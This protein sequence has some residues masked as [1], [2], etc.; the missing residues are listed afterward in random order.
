V[1]L[2]YTEPFT[3]VILK[4]YLGSLTPTTSIKQLHILVRSEP[5]V[6][7]LLNETPKASICFLKPKILPKHLKVP[8]I[9]RSSS[10][11]LALDPMARR[12]KIAKLVRSILL[13]YEM[14]KILSSYVQLRPHVSFLSHLFFDCRRNSGQGLILSTSIYEMIRLHFARISVVEQICPCRAATG[15]MT[16]IVTLLRIGLSKKNMRLVIGPSAFFFPFL[17]Y[18]SL[19]LLPLCACMCVCIYSYW[20]T[21]MT[22]QI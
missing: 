15:N 2:L 3:K 1:N 16:V 17:E 19:T 5:S 10:I 4:P 6:K 21:L 11:V 9:K 22:C 18:L 12:N 13:C 8:F 20:M 14:S 7:L